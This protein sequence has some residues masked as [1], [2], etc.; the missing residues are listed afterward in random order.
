ML[1]QQR[2]SQSAPKDTPTTNRFLS[3]TLTGDKRR[4]TRLQDVASAVNQEL[5]NMI[6]AAQTAEVLPILLPA[7][8]KVVDTVLQELKKR[9][10]YKK[11]NTWKG[12]QRPKKG[13]RVSEQSLYLPFTNI[14]NE[15]IAIIDEKFPG[16]R[17]TIKGKW[18]NCSFMIPKSQDSLA[19][20]IRPDVAYVS[21]QTKEKDLKARDKRLQELDCVKTRSM[22]KNS[23]DEK[24]EA[25]T[26]AILQIW[27]LQMDCLA[28]FKNKKTEDHRQD[29]LAQ[30]CNY[31]KQAFREQ[32]DRRFIIGFTLCLDELKLYLFDRS[33]VLES[34]KS[35][36]IHD[37][38]NIH[39]SIEAFVLTISHLG[40]QKSRTTSSR[41]FNSLS[42]TAR[43]GSHHVCI[44][45]EV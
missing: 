12:L 3:R 24:K 27:W 25:E 35:I 5:L 6:T 31:A 16:R 13:I 26:D 42:R 8:S 43:M 18:I 1:N 22:T 29:A 10:F 21:E 14:A 36:N 41:V 4:K 9:G 45:Q 2:I 19:A 40:A 23:L 39:F 30:L 38:S 7:E 37:A 17:N 32:L 34:Q 28:E 44:S 15:I 11:D 33:G 20:S